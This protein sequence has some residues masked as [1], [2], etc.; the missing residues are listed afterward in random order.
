LL[1]KERS[2][3]EGRGVLT[4]TVLLSLGESDCRKLGDKP[5]VPNRRYMILPVVR[6][7]EI[8]E[9]SSFVQFRVICVCGSHGAHTHIFL[10]TNDDDSRFDYVKQTC[11][12]NLGDEALIQ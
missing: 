9:L 10:T 12:G 2:R 11:A 3:I 6:F 1:E 4:F 7:T 5:S 8:C